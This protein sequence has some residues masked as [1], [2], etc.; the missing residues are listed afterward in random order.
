MKT[1]LAA[2]LFHVVVLDGSNG[3]SS[4]LRVFVTLLV[5]H[6]LRTE[7]IDVVSSVG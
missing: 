7:G 4:N 3:Y 2:Y 1:E 5:C 6:I